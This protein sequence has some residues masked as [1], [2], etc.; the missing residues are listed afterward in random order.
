MSAMN[1]VAV[2]PELVRDYRQDLEGD[3]LEVLTDIYQENT[4]IVIWKRSL[5]NDLIKA[6]SIVL[7]KKPNL[8]ELMVLT[9]SDAFSSVNK[10]LGDDEHSQLL[11]KDTT[12]LVDVFCCLFNVQRAILKLTALGSAMCPRFHVDHVPCR[13]ITTYQSA[14]TE[15]LPH[16][17][18]D[19]SK[20]GAGNNGKPDELSGLFKSS[21][22]IRQ[23]GLGDVA[24]LKGELWD[25]NKGAGLIHRSPQLSS[26]THR[27]L[28]TVDFIND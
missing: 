21:H 16:H 26:G 13:L 15:W 10:L 11:A 3:N 4:N 2:K 1:L 27:L 25:K 9:P 20:L 6:A 23:L 17:L 28:L 12:Q 5:S 14:A 18:A 19:R 8:E 7:E 22:D 24:L